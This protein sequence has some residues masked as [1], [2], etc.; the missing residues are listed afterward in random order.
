MLT[1]ETG[2]DTL[3]EKGIRP[4]IASLDSQECNEAQSSGFSPC[5]FEHGK[6]ESAHGSSASSSSSKPTPEKK[7]KL[8]SPARY[9]ELYT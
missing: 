2:W 1:L 8:L 3:M 9:V 5:V 4:L 6:T 7:H